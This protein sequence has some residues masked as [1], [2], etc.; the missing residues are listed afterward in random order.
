MGVDMLLTLHKLTK[1]LA[2]M[3]YQTSEEVYKNADI[4]TLIFINNSERYARLL[5]NVTHPANQNIY[6][7]SAKQ[8]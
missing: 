4:E 6:A 7:E 1:S 8:V 3:Y 5:E 2:K